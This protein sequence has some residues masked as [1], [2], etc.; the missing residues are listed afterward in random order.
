MIIRKSEQVSGRRKLVFF[1]PLAILVV[2]GICNVAFSGQLV[3]QGEKIHALEKNGIQ[4]TL[5]EKDLEA[6]LARLQSLQKIKDEA[7]TQGYLPIISTAVV[8][9]TRPVALR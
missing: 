4:L 7:I 6:S 3:N 8:D 5:N 9:G 2:L 1:L